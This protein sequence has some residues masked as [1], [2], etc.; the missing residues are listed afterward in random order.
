MIDLEAIRCWFREHFGDPVEVDDPD[1]L[2]A[3]AAVIVNSKAAP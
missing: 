1:V 3:A 2:D